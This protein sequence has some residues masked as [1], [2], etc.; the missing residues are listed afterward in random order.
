MVFL[1]CNNLESELEVYILRKILKRV[2]EASYKN[3]NIYIEKRE[4]LPEVST[5]IKN[6]I[7]LLETFDYIIEDD[8]CMDEL[9]FALSADLPEL[10]EKSGKF[11]LIEDILYLCLLYTSPSPR[12]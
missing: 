6:H 11:Y 3:K 2:E 10:T 7:S 4:F 5:Y 9:L 12:D 8:L 1:C